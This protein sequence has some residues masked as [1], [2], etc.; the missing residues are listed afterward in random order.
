MDLRICGTIILAICAICGTVLFCKKL[1]N[2]HTETM[3]WAAAFNRRCEDRNKA[4]RENWSEAN[5]DLV[6]QIELLRAENEQYK[7]TL[8]MAGVED[9]A[10]F[11]KWLEG[12]K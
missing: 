5:C 10:E 4:E 1:E 6:G 8:A 11:K 12:R 7:K 9:V 2:Q 3:T